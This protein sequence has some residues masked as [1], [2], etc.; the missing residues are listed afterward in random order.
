MA[1]HPSRVACLAIL[2][3][4]V[5]LSAAGRATNDTDKKQKKQK[6]PEV[7]V[8]NYFGGI[9][10]IGDGGIPRGPCFRINGRV[11]SGDFFNNLRSYDFDDGVIF[12]RGAEEVTEFPNKLTLSFSIHDEPCDY[13]LQAVGTGVYLT[14]EEMGA[15]KLALYWK[16]GVDMRPVDKIALEQS[17]V[18]PVVPY[19]K[20]LADELPKRYVWSYELG[21]PAG[22]VPL[23][24]SLV[25]IFRN[26]EG[27]IVAR[28]A[29]RL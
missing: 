17:S 3:V 20:T 6:P 29:A 7:R 1:V 13:G 26:A 5:C 28:V 24:D 15:L 16:R 10:F 25:L 18:V 21:V 22:D 12:R 9:F 8:E 27:H 11:T 23:T 14:P 19:A 2:G 4:L